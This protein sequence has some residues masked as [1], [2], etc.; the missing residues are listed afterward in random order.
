MPSTYIGNTG[1]A[2][3][4]RLFPC[5]YMQPIFSRKDTRDTFQW[6]VRN[7]TYPADVYSVSVEAADRKIVIR[8]SNKK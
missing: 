2:F 4:T 3:T 6:R 8:T 5:T 7:L 1:G